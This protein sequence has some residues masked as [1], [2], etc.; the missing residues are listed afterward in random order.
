MG[1]K[2]D[3]GRTVGLGVDVGDETR[4][5]FG[6]AVGVGLIVRTGTGNVA[7]GADVAGPGVGGVG[8]DESRVDE[9]ASAG[10]ANW[11]AE[12]DSGPTADDSEVLSSDSS[13]NCPPL[14]S[15][16]HAS[17]N[18]E[19]KINAKAMGTRLATGCGS[20]CPENKPRNF[21]SIPC[22]L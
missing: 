3:V 16:R 5:G 2:V 7:G 10:V 22:R 11:S 14:E 4:V 17:A 8:F 9:T 21:F 18:S 6:G 19:N 15:V 12:V 20:G 1:T 13:E